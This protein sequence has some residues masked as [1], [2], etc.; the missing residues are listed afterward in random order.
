MTTP[1]KRERSGESLDPPVD[2][3]DAD[4]HA[5][6]DEMVSGYVLFVQSQL[7]DVNHE[8][9]VIALCNLVCTVAICANELGKRCMKNGPREITAL[10]KDSEIQNT[11]RQAWQE[12]KYRAIRMIREWFLNRCSQAHA[13]FS[14]VS[15]RT[16][17]QE[18]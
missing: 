7:D 3:L 14:R 16:H 15:D 13:L 17:S 6:Q 5:D 12:K 8:N 11:V 4:Q 18:N 9:H 1:R 10:L 2:F